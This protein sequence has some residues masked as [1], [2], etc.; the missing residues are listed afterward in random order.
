MSDPTADELARVLCF[1]DRL[2][3][4]LDVRAQMR[5]L[6]KASQSLV[7]SELRECRQRGMMIRAALGILNQDFREENHDG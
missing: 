4:K 7:V 2:T 3:T 1:F 5:V 6:F